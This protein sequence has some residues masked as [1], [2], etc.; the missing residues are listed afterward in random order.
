MTSK[1]F[2]FVLLLA[3]VI[4]GQDF[5]E[6]GQGFPGAEAAGAAAAAAMAGGAGGPGAAG[7]MGGM[8]GGAGGGS[9]GTGAGTGSDNLDEINR[10]RAQMFN[11]F[12]QEKQRHAAEFKRLETFIKLKFQ[13]MNRHQ[14]AFAKL[15]DDMLR[16]FTNEKYSRELQIT[17]LKNDITKELQDNRSAMQSSLNEKRKRKK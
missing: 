16:A 9:D 2:F 3:V 15:K 7:G 14:A 1:V 17:R 12:N 8:G 5:Q 10:L 4:N 11:A 13:A 6:E